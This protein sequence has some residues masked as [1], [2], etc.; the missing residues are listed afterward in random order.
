MNEK[1][2]TLSKAVQV[3]EALVRDAKPSVPFQFK[4]VKEGQYNAPLCLPEQEPFGSVEV[5][6][7]TL[8]NMQTLRAEFHGLMSNGK[9]Q[10]FYYPD[11]TVA[12]HQITNMVLSVL[13][14]A[15]LGF[16]RKAKEV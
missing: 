10:R 12:A 4:Q 9:P 7:T 8:C 11:F 6:N 13:L 16:T 1:I 3:I 15:Q 14:A 5:K 2:T